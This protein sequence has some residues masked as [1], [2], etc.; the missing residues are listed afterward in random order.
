M[1]FLTFSFCVSTVIAFVKPLA[2]EWLAIIASRRSKFTEKS[3]VPDRLLRLPPIC[4]S[5]SKKN[6]I[7]MYFKLKYLHVMNLY[8]FVIKISRIM[9][10]K[11]LRTKVRNANTEKA[12]LQPPPPKNR[13]LKKI[14]TI[15]KCFCV[16]INNIS[17]SP[18]FSS[19][20]FSK[21]K[22]SKPSG[23]I[24]FTGRSVI[25]MFELAQL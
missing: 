8:F 23:K 11:R 7:F 20:L 19:R 21:L 6:S 5:K 2:N 15:K 24:F 3:S 22:S 10:S 14:K 4:N 17:Y 9:I 16:E 25:E 12:S 13:P 1:F 18:T